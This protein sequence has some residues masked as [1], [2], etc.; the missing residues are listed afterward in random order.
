MCQVHEIETQE[1]QTPLATDKPAA[2]SVLTFDKFRTSH[3]LHTN[4]RPSR[5]WEPTE[6]PK[7]LLMVFKKEASGLGVLDEHTQNIGSR[8]AAKDTY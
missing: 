3:R 4:T 2:C 5:N 6:P 8:A 7:P 1:L